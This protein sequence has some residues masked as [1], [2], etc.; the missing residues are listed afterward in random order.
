MTFDYDAELRRYHARLLAALDL[1][2]GDRVLDV[3]CGTGQM[4]RAVARVADTGDALG[5][6]NSPRM[7]AQARALSDEE[8]LDNVRFEC[9][10]AQSHPFPT[11]RFSLGVSRF[12]TMF[13]ADPVAAF[14]NIARSLRPGAPFVQLV[15]QDADRQEWE[16]AI[17][18]ALAPD[19]S[20]SDHAAFSLA[21][22]VTVR[23]VMTAGGFTDVDLT[24]LHEPIYYGPDAAAAR[25]SVLALAMPREFLAA[26]PDDRVDPAL[27]RLDG[28]LRARD[29]G[30]GVWFDS[31]AWLVTAR[32]AW[33]AHGAQPR[34]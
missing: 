1:G 18:S 10:D 21:D 23:D 29:T 25:G 11:E 6:D 8:G 15:W 28:M 3:G 33:S 22:P 20:W 27:D 5:V 31:R 16:S 12:G 9:G 4:T 19:A 13:F 7:V 26:L 30:D 17:R 32:R 14:A 34:R 2:S 24:E